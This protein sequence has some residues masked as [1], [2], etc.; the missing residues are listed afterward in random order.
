MLT[1]PIYRKDKM[2]PNTRKRIC[3]RVAALLTAPVLALGLLAPSASADG[4]LGVDTSGEGL[5]VNFD[6]A[7]TVWT[8]PVSTALEPLCLNGAETVKDDAFVIC[9]VTD[10]PVDNSWGIGGVP[11]AK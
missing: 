9:P 11:T 4:P 1:S 2:S 6:I 10:E 3:A 5:N 8:V 7:Q